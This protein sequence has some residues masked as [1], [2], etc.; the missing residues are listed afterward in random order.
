[1]WCASTIRSLVRRRRAPLAGEEKRE[2][3]ESLARPEHVEQDTV[4]DLRGDSC[5]EAPPDD[6]VQ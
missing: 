1:M 3:P 6:Q 5:G 2:L 4:S